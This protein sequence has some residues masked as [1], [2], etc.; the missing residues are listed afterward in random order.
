MNFPI[1]NVESAPE[2]AHKMLNGVNSAFGFIP[3]MIGGMASAPALLEGY[4]SLSGIFDK[5]SFNATERQVILLTT[6]RFNECHYCMAAHSAIAG[7]QGVDS[8]VVAALREDRPIADARLQALRLFAR[9]LVEKRGWV[10]E[11]EIASFLAAGFNAGQVLEVILG[12][13][14]KT[15]SNYANHLLDTPVDA[16]FETHAWSPPAD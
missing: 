15:L 13:G 8:D 14:V 10:D 5:T 9:Q 12:V 4:T 16:A 7:M 11:Q 6:S 2:A 3:N 1:H